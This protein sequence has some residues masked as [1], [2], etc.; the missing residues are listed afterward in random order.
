MTNVDKIRSMTDEELGEFIGAMVDHD[1]CFKSGCKI[2]HEGCCHYPFYGC[3]ENALE[4][5]KQEV[6][7]G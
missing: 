4:W 5:L 6:R 7:D 1:C 2:K 3:D